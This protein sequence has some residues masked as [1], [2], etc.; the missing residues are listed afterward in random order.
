MKKMMNSFLPLALLFSWGLMV[1]GVRDN[2][3][4]AQLN[5]LKQECKELISET[6][7]EGSKTT[8]YNVTSSKQQKTV[9]VF[10][11]LSN[12][13]LFAISA[14]KC[15]VPVA[16]KLY[17]APADSKDRIL[18][19]EIKKAQGA[20]FKFSSNELNAAYQKKKGN[21]DRLKNLYFE[22]QINSGSQSKEGIV[23]VYGSKS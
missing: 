4:D 14:K 12:E 5:T 11:F 15:S 3:L 19:K 9:E 8:Y 23:L 6:R 1:S 2:A 7:Y 17:D 20:N 18:I 22:Y 10:M 21:V 16:I 13:Y